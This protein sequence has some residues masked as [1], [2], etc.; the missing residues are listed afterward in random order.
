MLFRSIVSTRIVERRKRRF[1]NPSSEL[2]RSGIPIA[3]QSNAEDGARGLPLQALYAVQQGSDPDTVLRS[4]TYD[5]ARLFKI[6][7]R[8]GSL[9]P[10]RDADIVIFS[11][12][13]FKAGT[14]TERVIINGKEVTR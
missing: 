11:G 5:A 1:H 9:Q 10:G 6:D 3:F 7:D 8:T 13:P 14:R 2:T 4:L 12:H